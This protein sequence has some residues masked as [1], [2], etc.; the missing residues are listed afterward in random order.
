MVSLAGHLATLTVAR[1]WSVPNPPFADLRRAWGVASPV[2]S[3]LYLYAG[4]FTLV[5]VGLAMAQGDSG[6]R[7]TPQELQQVGSAFSLLSAAWCAGNWGVLK[8]PPGSR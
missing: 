1:R 6:R 3:L 4:G 5:V 8:L 7:L 2:F